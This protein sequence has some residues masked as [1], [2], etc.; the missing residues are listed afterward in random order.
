MVE[1]TAS[2]RSLLQYG[3]WGA[4]LSTAWGDAEPLSAAEEKPSDIRI[5]GVETFAL[6]HKLKKGI[7]PSTLY[8]PFRDALL[9]KITTD[10]G[11]VGWGEAADVGG[12]REVI[13]K[14]L[15]KI[16]L[17]KNPLE[18]RKLWRSLWGANFGDGRAV[19]GVDIAINDIRGKAM[20]LPIS[21]LFGGRVRNKA[22][23]YA[24]SM[25]YTEGVDPE[26][27]HPAEAMR[28]V[29]KGF[30]S[31]K[32][33]TGRYG[34]KRDINVL[35]M[36][37]D[38][39]GPDIRLQTDGNGGMTFANAVT[40]GKELEKL[41]FYFFEEPIPQRGP[42]YPGYPEL[43]AALDIPLAAGEVLDSRL[44]AKEL[45]IQKALDIIQP[46]PMLCGGI[47]ECIAIAEFASL[48]GIACHPHC[49]GSAPAIAATMHTVAC[50]PNFSQSHT[51]DEP[52]LEIDVYEN[53]FR[54]ELTSF[55]FDV[56]DG[57]IDLPTKPG[58]GI[59]IDEDVIKKYEVK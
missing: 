9:I 4:A 56:K 5:T 14:K 10:S 42:F 27:Q 28:L 53:P 47:G 26:D 32:A 3:A 33:R 11:I 58:L 39:V 20:N 13:E 50:I 19:G 57:Y 18:H 44:N 45:I 54:D 24:S 29:E 15:K 59:D 16:L 43:A 22:F 46:D 40:F 23:A 25:N 1:P 48:F 8:Y 35:A 55:R 21:E 41:D 52:M 30:R 12:T 38:A 36:V 51:P 17:G 31:L 2:R 6:Q 7:G 49:W 37:R 34:L